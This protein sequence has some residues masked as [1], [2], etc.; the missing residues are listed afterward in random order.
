MSARRPQQ[1]E[2]TAAQPVFWKNAH[3]LA[4]FNPCFCHE[5]REWTDAY[6]SLEHSADKM[7]G[8]CDKAWVL[9]HNFYCDTL[10]V[11]QIGC[12]IGHG[13]VNDKCATAKVGRLCEDAVRL[14]VA[15]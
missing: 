11:M 3:D 12:V 7:H 4:L 15:G 6:A 14:H 2:P 9:G 10:V 13:V 1:G 5:S 8:S